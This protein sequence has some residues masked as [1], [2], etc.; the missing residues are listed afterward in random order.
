MA[1]ASDIMWSSLRET[2]VIE[3]LTAPKGGDAV[4]L[5]SPT[6]TLPADDRRALKGL[7]RDTI[8]MMLAAAKADDFGGPAV[9]AG[10]VHA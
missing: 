3:G 7:P 8:D 10:L 2:Q 5:E 1:P 6:D 4:T 9:D